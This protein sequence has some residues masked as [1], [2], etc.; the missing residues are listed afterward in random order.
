MKN[1]FILVIL[2]LFFNKSSY[3][4]LLL[5]GGSFIIDSAAVVTIQGD[6]TSNTSIPGNGK[7]V[8]AGSVLQNIN[9]GGFAL[10]FLEINNAQN[11][12][13]IS[14]LRIEKA[15]TFS[16]GKISSASYN[17]TFSNGAV[18]SG[19]ADNKFIEFTG[20]GQLYKELSSNVASFELPVGA[21]VKYR[22]VFLTTTSSSFTNAKIGVKAIALTEPNKPIRNRDFLSTY[23]PV[24]RTGLIGSVF[25]SGQYVD[26]NDVTGTESN[27]KGYFFDGTD[28]SSAGGTNNSILNRVGAP[29]TG[30]GGNVY[31]MSKFIYLGAKAYLQGAYNATTGLMSE[32][33]RP[34]LPSSDPY[35]SSPY[36]TAFTHVNNPIAETIVGTPFV[37][38]SVL[39]NNIVDWVYLELRNTNASPG[40]TILQ[41]RSALIQRDGEIVEVDGVSPVSFY[42]LPDGNYA[43]TVR[44]R[45]HLSMSLSPTAG[46]VALNEKKSTS[47][48]TNLMD[49]ST[50]LPTKLYG[51]SAG[52]T[53]ANHPTFTTVNLLWGG[54]A[55]SNTNSKYSGTAND[56]AIIL[57]DLGNNELGTLS[58]YNR[59]D[60]NFNGVVKY[61]GAGNDR[62][63]LLS[64]GLANNELG[65]RT[66]QRPN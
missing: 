28:W 25:I 13:M 30:T 39:A 4:Q 49:L 37:S 64:S 16:Q 56:R 23:W 21:G 8:M 58:G 43:I 12:N 44:H 29:V 50:A 14:D 6:L 7:I 57:A 32:T 15:L 53:T 17:I 63:F 22:P 42:N 65:V 55:N 40:N 62:G 66:E 11:V 34:L 2:V 19:A 61:S 35:R 45:N 27:L 20:S 3:S 46:F 48:T 38:Q 41:T 51:T 36:N 31:G 26:I 18:S 52:Y 10:P 33:L 1:K 59:S 54:N 47:Y 24:T 60:L 9:M 5:N